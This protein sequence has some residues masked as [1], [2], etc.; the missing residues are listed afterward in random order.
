MVKSLANRGSEFLNSSQECK[1]LIDEEQGMW[2]KKF[3]A[4]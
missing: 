2:V 1:T 4:Y 3:Y